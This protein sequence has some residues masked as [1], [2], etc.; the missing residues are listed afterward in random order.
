MDHDRLFKLLLIT[1]FFE[2]MELLLPQVAQY[3]SRDRIE[4]LDKEIFTD[5]T[6]GQ[7]NEVD[8]LAKVKF[9][10][11]DAFFLM[12][13]EPMS[14]TRA[15]YS[16]TMFHYVAR[17]DEKYRLPV[18]PVVI[19]SFDK[20]LRP[21]KDQ[22][23]ILFPDLTVIDF[24]FRAIQLNRLD[25]KE[26]AE[27]DNPVASALMTRMR[28]AAQDRPKVKLAC[29]RMMLRLTLTDAQRALIKEFIDAYLQLTATERV[30]FEQE[31]AKLAPP[32][33]E[34]L[35]TIMNEWEQ[36][37]LEKGLEKGLA[38]FLRL[39]RRAAGDLSADTEQQIRK[40][41]VARLEQ[42]ADASVAFSSAADLQTWLDEHRGL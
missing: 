41:S 15:D 24:R 9:R 2:I 22:Y 42:L 28:I 17:L 3:L 31:A 27:K 1:F 7:R 5:L 26:F 37:G 40:L 36:V 14:A 20:P 10:D 33:K 19:F 34:R 8:V 35:M 30:E 16:R 38:P 23:Q 25:W 13:V 39:L 21:E 12:L 32:E 18:Y 6:S 4:F 11:K 29:I